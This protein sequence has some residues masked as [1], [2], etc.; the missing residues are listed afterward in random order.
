MAWLHTWAGLVIGAPLFAV[1]WMGTL[2][3]FDREIDRW[4]MPS[5]RLAAA[6]APAGLDAIAAAASSVV[7]HG[8]AHWRAWLPT[9]R[10]PVV[11]LAYQDADGRSVSRHLEPATGALLPDVGSWGGTG[12]FFPFHYSLHVS[13][14]RL[15]Y[16]LVGLLGMAM[17][18]L[19]VSGVVIHRKIFV[20]FFT[21][22]PGRQLPRSSLDL[23]NLTSIVALPFHFVM[24]LSGLIIFF[25]VLF[26]GVVSIVY[27]G[28][29]DRFSKEAYGGFPRAAA[30]VEGRLASLDAMAAEASRLWQ[31]G[32]PYF[33]RVWHPGDANSVVEMRRSFADTVTMTLDT[34]YFDGASGA[35]LHSHTAKPVLS[36]QRFISGLHFI[37]F[38]HWALRWLYFGL[39]LCGCVMIATGFVFWLA[40]RRRA[41]G[42]EGRAG[43]RLVE[44]L[45]VGSVAGI[46]IATLAFF[47][48][49]RLLPHGA[50]FLDYERYALE[51]WAFVLA[52]LAS[53]AHAWLRPPYAW[54][55]QCWTIASLAVLAV[56][57]NALTTG[58]HLVR[59]LSEGQW[60][61]A[62]MDLTLA[63]A[64]VAAALSARRLRR[65][66]DRT[67][68]ASGPGPTQS[69][70]QA[71]V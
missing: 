10:V 29:S 57:L 67:G 25:S 26:P 54:A 18:V 7:G 6:E 31:G 43:V 3:V 63:S 70:R 64:A 60:A 59:T 65:R 71:H 50:T 32:R 15:G 24:T 62:G 48:A 35:V 28:Q 17:L 34:V 41:H 2:C 30:G 19:L 47:V 4:M 52:W 9:P 23:H 27:Q 53:F 66:E 58:D 36:V 55:E 40:T 5:T 37:Q 14:K 13:W 11:K 42:A 46:L 21:F 22:R 44:G 1:F 51:I 49:N 38:E 39:G 8:A 20:D 61:V 56:I 12:F 45:T 33:V 68:H 69:T 16:W